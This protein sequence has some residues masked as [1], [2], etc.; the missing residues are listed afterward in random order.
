MKHKYGVIVAT[1]VFAAGILNA[2]T[3]VCDKPSRFLKY[4]TVVSLA[5]IDTDV[6]IQRG[7]SLE[8]KVCTANRT[9]LMWTQF[10]GNASGNLTVENSSGKTQLKVN[11]TTV[12]KTLTWTKPNDV[13]LELETSSAGTSLKANGEVICSTEATV[14]ETSA[15]WRFFAFS[16]LQDTYSSYRFYYARI[17]NADGAV[18][19]DFQPCICRGQVAVYD[20]VAKRCYFPD[21]YQNQTARLLAGAGVSSAQAKEL[22]YIQLNY[23]Q[24]DAG[25]VLDT[26]IRARSGTKVEVTFSLASVSGDFGIVG[27]RDD[28]RGRFMLAHVYQNKIR[29]GYGSISAAGDLTMEP[30]KTYTLVADYHK[31]SQTIDVDGVRVYTGTSDA[32]VDTQC[33]LALFATAYPQTAEY[34]LAP[35]G[36]RIGRVRIWQGN[37]DGSDY[38]LVRDYTPVWQ[39]GYVGF[40]DTEGSGIDVSTSYYSWPDVF[41]E[42]SEPETWLQYVESG[43]G[44]VVDTGVLAED[45]IKAELDIAVA[46]G[47]NFKYKVFPVLTASTA[48]KFELFTVDNNKSRIGYNGATTV[49]S[50]FRL[51]ERQTVVSE[52]YA[53]QQKLTVG[54]VTYASASGSGYSGSD[55]IQVFGRAEDASAPVR[56]YGLKIW[57]GAADGSHPQLIRNFKPA[58]CGGRVALYDVAHGKAYFDKVTV[59]GGLVAGPKVGA[60][61]KFYEYLEASGNQF[62]DTGVIGKTP[63][64]VQAEV[65][66]TVSDYQML[67]GSRAGND[68][69]IPLAANGGKW[70][71]A[72][73]G[74]WWDVGTAQV[75]KNYL[76]EATLANGRQILVVDD[77]TIVSQKVSGDVDTG[78]SLYAFA[79]NYY[80]A[81]NS[82]ASDFGKAKCRSLKIQSDGTPLR[83]FRA[84]RLDGH[85]GFWDAV[86]ESFFPAGAFPFTQRQELATGPKVPV[87]LILL[88]R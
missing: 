69:V 22:D 32:E 57:K 87:G 13:L 82:G 80:D 41:P 38:Q 61:P 52:A 68:R 43:F 77:E 27:A 60:K 10:F 8:M 30:N 1:T 7:Q 86:T 85:S 62:V 79:R 28:A 24:K 74:S 40:Y 11:G 36:T 56:L 3:F 45:G 81:S 54:G 50:T 51:G 67:L 53:G 78:L 39:D 65:E 9:G 6:P 72:H 59:R 58:I 64:E 55:T 16:D 23:K 2:A 66:W 5:R 75:G 42:G 21:Q 17:R 49:G 14:P 26:G 70:Q 33:N 25:A 34:F 18:I 76:V 48:T 19:A 31:G 15:T 71:L 37:V 73:G 29:C 84:C 44:A 35:T 88:V 4:V 83:D 46:Y 12:E 63:I 47:S 20:A